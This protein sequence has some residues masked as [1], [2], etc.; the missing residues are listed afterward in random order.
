MVDAHKHGVTV[1]VFG[2]AIQL[3]ASSS[4]LL[5]Q[6]TDL[7]PEGWA[8]AEGLVPDRRYHLRQ[9]ADDGGGRFS[10]WI[11]DRMLLGNKVLDYSLDCFESDLQIFLGDR[12]PDRVFIHA[13]VVGWNDRAIVLPGPS[14]AGKSTLVAEFLRRGA[15]YYSDEFAVV[16]PNGWIDPYRRKLSLRRSGERPLRLAGSELG[17]M[18]TDGPV[19]PALIVFA[20][21]RSGMSWEP[22]LL[23]PGRTVLELMKNCLCAR[24][25]PEAAIDLLT[26][27]ACKTPALRG[28]RGEAEATVDRLIHELTSP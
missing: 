1:A 16:R 5:A 9:D 3:R 2:L 26:R 4:R 21:Y 8:S 12:C 24:R 6:L 14:H 19:D 11:D 23:P 10:L 20:E 27:I 18:P 15:S 28:V 22:E 25:R 7:L 17:G 13:G